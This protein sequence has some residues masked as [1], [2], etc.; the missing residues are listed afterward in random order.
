MTYR[1]IQDAVIDS[2]FDEADR[3]SV[4]T[5][6]Q[7]RHAW[8]WDSEEWVFKRATDTVTFTNNSQTVASVPS[9]FSTALALYDHNGTALKP[10]LD[11]TEFLDR[12]N[13]NL[14]NSGSPE[15]YTVIDSTIYVGPTGDGTNGI[16]LYERLK[17]ALSADAD[18]TELPE[19]Y[20]LALVFGAKAS[21]FKVRAIP[22]LFAEMDDEFVAS[23]NAMRR[24]Y[25]VQIRGSDMRYGAYRAGVSR[26]SAWP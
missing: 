18:G 6:I 26:T 5:W 3:A 17:P 19:G 14:S 22:F 2:A 15:A 13:A 20:D 4:K 10:Y 8:L 21:G 7:A 24:N 11:M 12:Y 9:D 16:L 1:E 25:L 23:V